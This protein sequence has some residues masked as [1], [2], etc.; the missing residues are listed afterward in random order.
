[1]AEK[2]YE[3][4]IRSVK[5]VLQDENI[6]DTEEFHK[7]VS[8][9][10]EKI[11]KSIGKTLGPGGGY[12]IISNIDSAAP[13]FPTK[14]GY[15]VIQEYKF[16]DQIKF[17]IAEII[18]DIPK[19]MNV[20]VGDSTT[21]GLI[22]AEKLYTQL[23][24]YDIQTSYPD[25]GC[26]LPPI[27]IRTILGTICEILIGKITKDTSYILK[28]VEKEVEAKLI[29]RVATIAANNDPEIGNLVAD[30]FIKRSSD[31]VFIT[32]EMGI[33][34]ETSVET[35]VGFKFGAGFTM[36]I[37]A[38]QVD[39]IT[40]KLQ[41]P[42]F[43]L[44]DGPLTGNDLSTVNM[45]IDY[46]IHD[47]NRSIVLV[48]KDYDQIV[49][50]MLSERCSRNTV[51][52]GNIPVLHEKEPIAALTINTEFEKSRDRLE[53]LRILLGCEIVE[54]KKGKIMS[55][56]SNVDFIEKFLGEAEEFI[57][58]Q[59]STR[60]KRGKGDKAAVMERITHI[61]K[62][63][64]EIDLTEGILAFSSIDNLKRRISMMTSDMAV[65]RVGGANDKERRAKRLIF[66]DVVCACS[67][68]IDHGFAIG[69]NIGIVHYLTK[70]KE[71]MIKEVT[72]K[73]KNSS[74]SI[75]I[76]NDE[77][78]IAIIVR[79]FINII[80][81]S[82][83]AAYTVVVENCA[84]I[85]TVAT[86]NILEKVYDTPNNE[87]T[88]FNLVSGVY[89]TLSDYEDGVIVPAN[90]DV[91]LLISIFG[92]VGTLVSSDQFL[93]IFPGDTT[94]YSSTGSKTSK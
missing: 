61:E 43:L 19:R 66:D 53:D 11:A 78:H 26:I 8:F 24:D 34:D 93:S 79:D 64:K 28:D 63:I 4:E 1:M 5:D 90:T 87:P 62:R 40:C 74:R 36:P 6:I 65:I 3:K 76:G 45:I 86:N 15:T 44:V 32:T 94:I 85:D 22:I 9:V 89:N 81:K 38:N 42:K 33:E 23:R 13:V 84:G 88:I 46:V 50:N 7:Q 14:D 59:L 68:A 20:N 82:F 48:A 58:T 29:K 75:I 55:F 56:K 12:T 54:T 10:F 51:M 70:N 52:K 57:G 17:F 60:I 67:S 80:I 77:K 71:E 21:S 41:N 18:K 16:N 37:M 35:E 2:L 31:H 69:G 83:K 47:L 73:L 25:M 27:S 39:R 72:N 92:S 30:L 49:V 91:E